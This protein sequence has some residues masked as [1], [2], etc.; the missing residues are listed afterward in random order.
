MC[1]CISWNGILKL[2]LSGDGKE[3]RKCIFQEE[4]KLLMQRN[5]SP[6]KIIIKTALLAVHLLAFG[7]FLSCFVLLSA[8]KRTE[9]E[10]KL[11]SEE[12]KVFSSGKFPSSHENQFNSSS[13]LKA[14]AS[15]RNEKLN[16][17]RSCKFHRDF[18]VA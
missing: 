16:F 1:F 4:K 7:C 3:L 5:L 14:A 10:R 8:F 2:K 18:V 17:C 15:C 6:E 9:E 11:L 13:H 12:W